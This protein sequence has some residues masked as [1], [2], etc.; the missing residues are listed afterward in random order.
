MGPQDGWAAGSCCARGKLECICPLKAGQQDVVLGGRWGWDMGAEGEPSHR[1]SQRPGRFALGARLLQVPTASSPQAAPTSCPAR[2]HLLRRPPPPPSPQPCLPRPSPS[3]SDLPRRP[4]SSHGTG[5]GPG[6]SPSAR[7]GRGHIPYRVGRAASATA[8]GSTCLRLSAGGAHSLPDRM[9]G[10]TRPQLLPTW[11]HGLPARP[12]LS[13]PLPLAPR[14]PSRPEP[15][16]PDHLPGRGFKLGPRT[17]QNLESL[18]NSFHPPTPFPA[19][20]C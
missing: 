11:P 10:E 12:F 1:W 18:C 20:A 5:E 13:P 7:R 6:A 15:R 16:L 19:P 17:A 3:Q 2:R 14:L 4:Q 8:T 9:A